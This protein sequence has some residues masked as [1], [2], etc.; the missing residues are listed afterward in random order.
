M[1]YISPDRNAV[2][3]HCSLGDSGDQCPHLTIQY[4]GSYELGSGGLPPP[5]LLLFAHDGDGKALFWQRVRHAWNTLLGRQ[6]EWN[7][8]LCLLG[9]N[10]RDTEVECVRELARWLSEKADQY[11]ADLAQCERSHAQRPGEGK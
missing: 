10:E 5:E 8:Y 7:Q 3:V 2:V 9:A 11:E 1:I 4:N 6:P